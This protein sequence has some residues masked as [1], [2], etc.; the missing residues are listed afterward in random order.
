MANNYNILAQ[1]IVEKY[2][3]QISGSNLG[4]RIVGIEP[5]NFARVFKKFTG[6]PP[7]YYKQ[8]AQGKK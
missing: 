7:S 8:N 4:D 3:E 5:E 1:H 6:H 2:I